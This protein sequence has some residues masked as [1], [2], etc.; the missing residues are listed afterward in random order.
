[1]KL[2]AIAEHFPSPYKVYHYV[3]FEQFLKE[4]HELTVYAFGKHEGGVG[5][6]GATGNFV[7]HT[8]YLPATLH[9]LPK[10][11]GKLLVNF[12]RHPWRGAQRAVRAFGHPASFKHRW[13]NLARALLLPAQAPD[14]C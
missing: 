10:F 9:E 6:S 1:M 12:C 13:L 14:V 3:Q 8:R 11:L 5:R 4:G 7:E 2:L